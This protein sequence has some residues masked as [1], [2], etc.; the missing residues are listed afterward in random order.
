[1]EVDAPLKVT[2]MV[3]G[4]REQS[5]GL[6]PGLLAPSPAWKWTG[7]HTPLVEH[8]G[9]ART[10]PRSFECQLLALAS[11]FVPSCSLSPPP[12]HAWALV[13]PLVCSI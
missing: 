1:M 8:G 7:G 10:G 2:E 5:R 12:H 11:S 6:N 4:W 3:W 13:P 9:Q